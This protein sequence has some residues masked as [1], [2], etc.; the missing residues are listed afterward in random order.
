MRLSAALLLL[1]A[2]RLADA[3]CRAPP[4]CFCD[5]N[6]IAEVTVTASAPGRSEA[7]VDFRFPGFDSDAGTLPVN[8]APAVGTELFLGA[9]GVTKQGDGSFG[10]DGRTF[11]RD[12][13]LALTAARSTGTCEQ[14]Y[15]VKVPPPPCHDVIGPFGCASG[16][17]NLLP[18]TALALLLY[19]FRTGSRGTGS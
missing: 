12:E 11:T 16:S 8:G 5:P 6:D 19:R 3:K 15:R 7:R 1:L 14:E 4:T 9:A 17:G 10:C 18:L 13:A 2:A